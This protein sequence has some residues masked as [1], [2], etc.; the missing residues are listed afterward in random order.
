MSAL[1]IGQHRALHLLG[2]R[3]TQRMTRLKFMGASVDE[4]VF[5]IAHSIE[6]AERVAAL[7][8]NW[9]YLAFNWGFPPELEA[10]DWA[11]FASA[12]QHYHRA[13]IQVAGY[14]QTSNCVY[15]GSYTQK[16]W[17]ALSPYG[18]KIYYYTGRYFTSLCHSGWLDEV[19]Q[20]VQTLVEAQ[21]DGI[22]FDNLWGGGIGIDISEMPLGIIGSYDEASLRAYAAAYNGAV[23]PLVL[24]LGSPATRQ[25]L[26][27]RSEIALT[28]LR[29][30][31]ETAR[32]INPNIIISAND[33][34]AIGRNALVGLGIDLENAAGIQDL[35]FIENFA[36]PRIQE[37]HAVVSN[38]ITIG[39][40][41]AR[42][43]SK[44]VTTL[45]GIE[46]VGYERIPTAIQ[47]KRA[48]AEATAMNAPLTIKGSGFLLR[49]IFT[50]ILHHRYEAQQTALQQM[51]RWLEQHH[52]WLGNRRAATPL[53]I[54]H[55]YEAL[56][57][58]WNKI[59]PIF[60]AACQTLLLNGY[61][62]RIVGDDD[63]WEHVRILIVPPG[64]VPGL[65]DRLAAFVESGGI[66][67]PLT[68]ARRASTAVIWQR[69]R[70]FR[71]RIPRWRWLRR[72]LN[73][74]AA[75]SW[76]F[77]HRYRLGRWIGTRLKVH[78]AMTQSPLY[79]VP[80]APLQ[81]A[82][83]TAITYEGLPR[84]VAEG[85]TLLT[86][87]E[88]GENA[89][90]WHIV[91]YLDTPQQVTLH[92]GDLTGAWAYTVGSTDMPTWVVGSEL[93]LTVETGKIIRAPRASNTEMPD[94]IT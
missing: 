6:G 79:F 35:M 65:E 62:L 1:S 4:K 90:Q 91:N 23:I 51:N 28:A 31:S 80:P 27:W 92:L 29:N 75:I 85:P 74:G 50:L 47:I 40:A 20:R 78:R 21:A 9:V 94:P 46:G 2:G 69:W 32:R 53:A 93:M 25:Y 12:V 66:V 8:F 19:H 67:V 72:R 33:F 52:S 49:N 24:D 60:F 39:A 87:W 22:F 88:E 56:H 64:D 86:I 26:R 71:Y 3:G 38:A 11:E 42:C 30:W 14:I 84:A 18:S 63:S 43:G 48:I 59:A 41:Q 68:E 61:P 15:T 37:N 45:P 83:L 73:H 77:Y 70:P 17:Y 36:L 82:L 7:G 58:Q 34:D 5:Q 81:E 76:H 10:A 16:D 89:R 44:P 54:Y 55:P 13:G 57:W